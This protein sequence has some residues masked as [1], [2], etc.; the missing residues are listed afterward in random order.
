MISSGQPRQRGRRVRHDPRLIKPWQGEVRIQR[1]LDVGGTSRRG[2][3]GKVPSFA[4]PWFGS[5]RATSTSGAPERAPQP[6]AHP[7]KLSSPAQVWD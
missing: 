4:V 7:A 5:L 2:K 3:L 6:L 1:F